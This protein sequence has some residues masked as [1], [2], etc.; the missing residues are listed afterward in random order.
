MVQTSTVADELVEALGARDFDRIERCF[1]PGVRFRALIPPG[2]HEANDPA[3]V[4]VHIRDWFAS[5]DRF[6]LLESNSEPV[7]DRLRIS[8]R[9]RLHDENG[10][11]LCQQQAYCAVV[12]DRIALM[13]LLCSGFRPENAANG[14]SPIAGRSSGDI[15]HL[16]PGDIPA[17]DA[18][19]DAPNETCSTLTPMI[20]AKLRELPSGAVLAVRTADPAAS[21]DLAS[22]SRLTGNELLG[23]TAGDQATTFYVRKK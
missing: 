22:W 7:G 18:R 1:A 15:P 10:W 13:D 11:Q 19:L 23:A 12:G 5:P 21:I 3:G 14:Q 4:I 6:E 17:A 2:L 16:S 20:R 9:L 8:Y